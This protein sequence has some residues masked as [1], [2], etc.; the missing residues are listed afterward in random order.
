VP[1][2]TGGD[3]GE[4]ILCQPSRFPCVPQV[5]REPAPDLARFV[6]DGRLS[7]RTT[8]PLRARARHVKST[9]GWVAATGAAISR[10]T[11]KHVASRR[12]SVARL[13]SSLRESH[14]FANRRPDRPSSCVV[15][16]PRVIGNAASP[17]HRGRQVCGGQRIRATGGRG[18]AGSRQPRN[19][20]RLARGGRGRMRHTFPRDY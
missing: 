16:V 12:L 3:S 13:R 17:P 19:L 14:G 18:K 11:S 8:D 4:R 6:M 10:E 7:R 15:S 1:H 20:R 5:A 2:R 9:N